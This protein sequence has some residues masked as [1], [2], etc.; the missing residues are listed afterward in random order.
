M[1]K[2]VATDFK[3][4]LN[5]TALSPSINSVTLDVNSNEVETTTFG[6]TFKTVVGGIISGSAKL[7]FYQDFA[8]GSVDA[9]IWPLINTIG[10][11][12]LTPTSATVS[13]TNPSYTAQVLINNY[14]PINA[15]IGDLAGFSV[16]WP[17]TGTVT[18]ATA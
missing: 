9:Q 11:L 16:T 13:A 7:D 17:T 14:Q 5:G 8:A 12:V 3:I 18:R 4:T 6:S 10:T 2:F 15:S 1:A